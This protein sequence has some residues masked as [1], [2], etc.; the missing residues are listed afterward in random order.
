MIAVEDWP[1]WSCLHERGVEIRAWLAQTG[2]LPNE[3]QRSPTTG[4]PIG[5][6]RIRSV[7]IVSPSDAT[8][9]APARY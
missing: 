9:M 1:C 3:A 6:C 4:L 8:G 7:P 2:E 5:C